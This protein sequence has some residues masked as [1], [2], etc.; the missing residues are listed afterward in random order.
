[1]IVPDEAKIVR[2]AK[3]RYLAGET[4]DKIWA[5]FNERGIPNPR[6]DGGKWIVS[7][8][9]RLLR[10]PGVGGRQMNNRDGGERLT[11]LEYEPIITWPEHESLVARLDSRA[12]RAGISPSNVFMLTSIIK[13]VN[14]NP[15]YG[16][17]GRTKYTYHCRKGCG[18]G[19]S[20]EIADSEISKEVIDLCGHLPH[21]VRRVIP[22]ENYLDQIARKR[23]DIRELDPEGD[24]ERRAELRV[25]IEHLRSLPNKPDEVRW[26]PSGKTI[27][28]YWESLDVSG[29][30]DW[31]R[32]NGWT[33]TAIKDDEMPNGWRLSIDAGWTANIGAGRQAE[34][35][36]FPVREY[37]RTLAGLGEQ[38][39]D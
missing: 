30:R 6:R 27:E 4:L 14:E 38:L 19:V 12:H 17:L 21:L 18:Y 34:C 11:I 26:M 24:D 15:M 33:I 39:P 1:V 29:R 2:E 5:D 20:M 28:E 8:L 25:E 32:E 35:L 10:N 3:D 9:G 7:T 13:D 31:L 16:H 36:G 22:G 23:Q 37:Y